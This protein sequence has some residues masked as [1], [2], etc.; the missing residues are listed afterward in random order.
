M[1]IKHLVISGGGPVMFRAMG[2]L[3]KLE[4]DNFWNRKDTQSIFGTSAGAFVAVIIC[5]NYDWDTILKYFVERPWHE[6]F[7]ITPTSL[8][9][10]MVKKI[11]DKSIMKTIFK[12]LFDDKDISLTITMKEFLRKPIYVYISILLNFISLK[13]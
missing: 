5:L 1:T 10:L 13:Q 2:A 12:P 11:Y 6:A 9:M 3:Q 4:E 8:L 7:P